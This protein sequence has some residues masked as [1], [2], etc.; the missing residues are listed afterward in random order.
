MG[1][2]MRYGLVIYLRDL[3]SRGLKGIQR[4]LGGVGRAAK[5]L[6]FGKAGLLG[7]LGLGGLAAGGIFGGLVSAAK[8]AVGGVVRVFRGLVRASEITLCYAVTPDPFYMWTA[9]ASMYSAVRSNP[10]VH[11]HLLEADDDYPW[12]LHVRAM[13]E[14]QPCTKWVIVLDSDTWITGDLGALLPAESCDIS[15]R[16]ALAWEKGRIIHKGWWRICN[17]AG[18][19]RVRVWANGVMA[20]RSD[21]VASLAEGIKRWMA[22]LPE[23]GLPDPARLMRVKDGVRRPDWWMRDQYALAL[24]VAELGW[25]V[26]DLGPTELSLNYA[27]EYDGIVHHVGKTKDLFANKDWPYYIPQQNG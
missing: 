13:E 18:V 4:S 26:R 8:F 24:T 16:P 27:R 25:S 1:K 12:G 7:G 10:G 21:R 11:I 15:L 3:V 5:G 23:R 14:A 20:M 22:W 9:A 19:P 2:E 17:A 6:A